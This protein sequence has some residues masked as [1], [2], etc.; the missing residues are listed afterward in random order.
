MSLSMMTAYN[1][2]LECDLI[3]GRQVWHSIECMLMRLASL[4]AY[5]H[6][7]KERVCNNLEEV[8]LRKTR[9]EE[10]KTSV[11]RSSYSR[12]GEKKG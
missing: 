12:S 6:N 5:G 3:A 9:L 7:T 8:C 1:P 2:Q 4:Y 10:E 11:S